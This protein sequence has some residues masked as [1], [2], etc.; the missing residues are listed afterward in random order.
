MGFILNGLEAEA[1]DR[2]YSDSAL[3]RRITGYFR[4]QARK[5][6][7]VALFVASAALV[8]TMI[9]LGVA[10]GIDL[11]AGNPTLQLLLALAGGVAVLGSLSWMFNFL[12][13]KLA[14]E[15][16]GD[17]VL[18]LREDAFAAVMERD[19]SFFDQFPSG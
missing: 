5:M 18:R 8:E 1:Y 10:R 9:P 6:I 2:S 16:V 4:P 12:R 14:A 15:A 13:Q 19:L 7:A 11:L 3:I 17:V